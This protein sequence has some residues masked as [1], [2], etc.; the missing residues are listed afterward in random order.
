MSSPIIF[1]H[2][3]FSPFVL[4]HVWVDKKSGIRFWFLHTTA[5]FPAT[6]HFAPS[7]LLIDLC[8]NV[9]GHLMSVIPADN[10][11]LALLPNS[12]FAVIFDDI[13]IFATHVNPEWC[14]LTIEFQVV[15]LKTNCRFSHYNLCSFFC[16]VFHPFSSD[17]WPLLF[18]H[19]FI[20]ADIAIISY[21]KPHNKQ[22]YCQTLVQQEWTPALFSHH[23]LPYYF[24]CLFNVFS[25]G[26]LWNFYLC[27]HVRS[28]TF[29]HISKV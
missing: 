8:L 22:V 2:T 14:F 15:V 6:S 21:C 13:I 27:Q 16:F 3:T 1:R 26:L 24:R 19:S 4:Y 18:L 12:V 9:W 7:S 29:L 5:L 20:I 11:R 28:S 10:G 25:Y 17:Y 23:Y